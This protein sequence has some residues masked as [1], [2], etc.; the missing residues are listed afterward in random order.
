[1]P[2]RASHKATSPADSCPGVITDLVLRCGRGDEKALGLLFDLFYRPVFAA[3]GQQVPTG[4]QE[5]LVMKVFLNLWRQASTYHPDAQSAIDWVMDEAREV[6]GHSQ[7]MM[8]G[9]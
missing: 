6:G 4:H 5:E 3:V 2:R 8:V 7:P 1:M 9:S